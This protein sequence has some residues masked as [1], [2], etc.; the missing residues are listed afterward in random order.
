MEH[1]ARL[2]RSLARLAVLREAVAEAQETFGRF[3]T[4]MPR[5]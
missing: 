2:R 1:V 5:R 4:V 3:A